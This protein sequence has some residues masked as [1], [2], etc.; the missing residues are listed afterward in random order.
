MKRISQKGTAMNRRIDPRNHSAAALCACALASL[1]PVTSIAQLRQDGPEGALVI[2]ESFDN[3]VPPQLPAGWDFS[4]G[5]EDRWDTVG[6]DASSAPNAVF[7]RD[8]PTIYDKRLTTPEFI[9]I[10]RPQLKFRHKLDMDASPPPTAVTFDGVVLEVSLDEGVTYQDIFA[11]G[12]SFVSGGYDH[13]VFPS[14]GNPLA[15]RNAWGGATAVYQ[16]VVVNLP[17]ASGG[18]QAIIVSWR[19]GTDN[20]AGG[21]GYWLDDVRVDLN[22]DCIFPDGFEI[23]RLICS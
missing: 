4:G 23:D 1:L 5:K 13:V 6:S 8:T 9:I 22:G 16:D 10:G 21:T 7:T 18:P 14:A 15:G 20:F 11:A 3:V 17:P 12:G 2:S 19:M